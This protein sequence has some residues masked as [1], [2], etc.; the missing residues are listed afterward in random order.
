MYVSKFST[1]RTTGTNTSTI[2]VL[3]ST[4]GTGAKYSMA[5]TATS[6][7]TVLHVHQVHQ[8]AL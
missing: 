8:T 6:T 1:G 7:G 5:T 4:V 2:T 3:Q